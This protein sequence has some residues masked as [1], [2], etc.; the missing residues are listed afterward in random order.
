MYELAIKAVKSLNLDLKKIVGECF[1]GASN[2][3]GTNK[4]LATL[5]KQTSPFAI[6]VH[7]Y[8]H[9]LNLALQDAMSSVECLKNALGT[10]QSLYNFV[11][12]SAKRVA[13]F[14]DI[15]VVDTNFLSLSLKSL[16]DTRWACR[17]DAMRAI[18]EQMERVIK[19]LILL[20]K[21]KDSKTSSDARS[22]L[23]SFCNFD[24]ILSHCILKIILS[25]TNALSK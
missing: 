3:S 10:I 9:R 17:Y 14:K 1:D 18:D 4:G 7:C 8:A 23:I 20:S 21:D 19:V 6:Y 25:N 5:M 11:G 22:L 13:T 16:S 15:E 24:F 2:M 12:A